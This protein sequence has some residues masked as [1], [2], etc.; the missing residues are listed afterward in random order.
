[1]HM[2][3][4]ISAFVGFVI[5]MGFSLSGL[6]TPPEKFIQKHL[7]ETRDIA[8]ATGSKDMLTLCNKA[9]QSL[10]EAQKTRIA[11]DADTIM[12]NMDRSISDFALH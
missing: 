1:M 9:L 2:I 12:W 10:T 3:M 8:Q 4:I 7:E 6:D 11:S 5:I